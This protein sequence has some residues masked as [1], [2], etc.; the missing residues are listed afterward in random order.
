M[1]QVQIFGL[2]QFQMSQNV[3]ISL[4]IRLSST[5]NA[6]RSRSIVSISFCKEKDLTKNKSFI[7]DNLAINDFVY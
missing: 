4:F 7:F 5:E 1:L 2:K 3:R 6:Y